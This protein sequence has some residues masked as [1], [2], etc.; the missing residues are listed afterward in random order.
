MCF[1]ERRRNIGHVPYP[2]GDGVGVKALVGEGEGFRIAFDERH[3]MVEMLRLGTLA[4]V[5]ML[6]CV[7]AMVGVGRMLS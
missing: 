1:P 2:E 7:G 6:G 4:A 3:L 5:A